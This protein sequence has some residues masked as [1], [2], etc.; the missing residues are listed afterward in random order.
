MKDE[1]AALA[2]ADRQ[3]ALVD[4]TL[5][6]HL[7]PQVRRLLPKHGKARTWAIVGT[8]LAQQASC[9]GGPQQ[10]A[11]EMLVAAAIKLVEQE[12][13]QAGEGVGGG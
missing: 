9:A 7:L 5:N 1:T 13:Q 4:A 8:D 11:V 3:L 12:Q 10:F 6:D 2:A